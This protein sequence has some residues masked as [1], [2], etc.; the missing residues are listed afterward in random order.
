MWE[1]AA[2]CHLQLF[3]RQVYSVARFCPD[4]SFLSLCHRPRVAGLSML[5]KVNSKSNRCLFSKPPAASN[6][7]QHI[8]AAAAAHPLEFEVSRCRTSQFAK[9]FLKAQVRLCNDLPGTVFATG[10]LDGFKGAANRWL[11]V[12]VGLRN[13][14]IYNFVFP[15]WACAA[16]FNNNN[17]NNEFRLS[18]DVASLHKVTTCLNSVL[19]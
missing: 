15:T 14:F 13:Q 6:R 5:Y 19:N 17:N 12:L 10:T 3:E 7:V 9:S 16:G 2:E 18:S 1:S 4:Q 11:Q 8:G